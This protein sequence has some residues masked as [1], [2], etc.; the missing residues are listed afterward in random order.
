[1]QDIARA[2][3]EGAE[4]LHESGSTPPLS[5][6]WQLLI[7]VLLA[8]ALTTLRRLSA[9]S[10]VRRLSAAAGFIGMSVAV[11]ANVRTAEAGRTAASGRH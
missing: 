1:M 8:V 2:I 7:A 3:Q 5:R 11:R 4:S 9:S 6:L 10:S